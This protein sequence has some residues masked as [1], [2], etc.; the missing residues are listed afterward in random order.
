MKD[1]TKN[2]QN[3]N[4]A[5][6]IA[7]IRQMMEKTRAET[8]ESGF[9]FLLWGWMAF[10]ACLAVYGL[11]FAGQARL[12]WLPWAIL[13]PIAAVIEVVYHWRQ[14]G[15]IR[16]TTYAQS[17]SRSLWIVCGASLFLIAFLALPLKVIPLSALSIVIAIILAIACFTTGYIIDW[18]PL[19]YSGVFWWATAILMMFVHWHWHMAI[20][21]IALIPGY[22]MPGYLLRKKY[23]RK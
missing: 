20:F 23:L 6:E 19:K 21:A 4:P 10:A 14:S 12:S 1:E 9:D 5:D 18:N 16:V 22:L 15:K 17:A 7:I 11:V 8:A 3:C 2:T 13:M